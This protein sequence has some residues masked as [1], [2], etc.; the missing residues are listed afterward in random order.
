MRSSSRQT[1]RSARAGGGPQTFAARSTAWQKA[2]AC[3]KLES[4]EMLLGQ[5][6]AVRQWDVLE[7]LLRAL[8]RVEEPDLEVEHRLAGYAK[9]EMARLDDAR[10]HRSHRALGT[11]LPLQPPGTYAARPVKGGSTVCKSKSLRSG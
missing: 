1:V 2:V 9:K 3:A 11:R 7:Q 5:W 8:V 6:D 10:M 4:P